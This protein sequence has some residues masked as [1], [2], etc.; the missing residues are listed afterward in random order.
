VG[1]G[2]GVKKTR[3]NPLRYLRGSSDRGEIGENILQWP[4]Q[5][6]GDWKWQENVARTERG[7][8]LLG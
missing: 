1:G 4:M 5:T 6:V 7:P 3:E 8:V 2:V